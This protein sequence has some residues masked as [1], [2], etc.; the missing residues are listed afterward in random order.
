MVNHGIGLG[1]RDPVDGCGEKPDGVKGRHR[2]HRAGSEE[3][4]EKCLFAVV[5]GGGS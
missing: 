1:I 5:Q 3:V 2:F 4:L